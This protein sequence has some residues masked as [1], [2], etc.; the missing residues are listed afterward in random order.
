MLN[1]GQQASMPIRPFG[2]DIQ[3]LPLTLLLLFPLISSFSFLIP[4]IFS[5]PYISLGTPFQLLSTWAPLE[6]TVAHNTP[7]PFTGSSVFAGIPGIAPSVAAV[8]IC[9]IQRR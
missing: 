1:P 6:S 9:L 3:T 5:P 4:F 2:V 8:A 7:G